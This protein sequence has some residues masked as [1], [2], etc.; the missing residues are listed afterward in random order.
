MGFNSVFKG[1]IK[2]SDDFSFPKDDISKEVLTS[3][4]KE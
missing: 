3:K 2:Y 1:L 4:N